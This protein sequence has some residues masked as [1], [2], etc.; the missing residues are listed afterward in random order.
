MVIALAW[1]KSR[2]SRKTEWSLDSP[3]NL[4]CILT[5]LAARDEPSCLY[6]ESGSVSI[7]APFGPQ[8][9]TCLTVSQMAGC[10]RR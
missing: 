3:G 5:R 9:E 2:K 4:G 10:P 6:L 1:L 7:Q 8:G